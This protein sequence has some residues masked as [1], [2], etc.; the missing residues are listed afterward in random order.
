MSCNTSFFNDDTLENIFDLNKELPKGDWRATIRLLPEVQTYR[1]HYVLALYKNKDNM[2]AASST[3]FV[4][5]C[6]YVGIVGLAADKLSNSERTGFTT[7][8]LT[9]PELGDF[10]SGTDTVKPFVDWAAANVR[11]LLLRIEKSGRSYTVSGMIEGDATMADGKQPAW[12]PLQ[13]LTSL[14]M[15]GDA[16]VMAFRQQVYENANYQVKGG[17]SL[18]SVD[19]I[20]IETLAAAE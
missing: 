19:W 15:P 14:R 2:L 16:I 20:R 12:V 4:K 6:G 5:C 1:E 17:E 8:A 18:V 11:A 7:E 10:R 9:S 3:P 13:Q